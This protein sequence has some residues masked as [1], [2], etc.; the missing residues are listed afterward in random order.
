MVTSVTP[1]VG[2]AGAKVAVSPVLG[3]AAGTA[4]ASKPHAI[5]TVPAVLATVMTIS[6]RCSG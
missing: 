4:A 6:G 3:G 2:L 1:T 5:K